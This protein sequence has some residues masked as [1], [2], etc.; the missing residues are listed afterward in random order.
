MKYSKKTFGFIAAI[1]MTIILLLPVV[2]QAKEID[3]KE[4]IDWGIQHNYDL[5]EIRYNIET[6]ERNLEIL[7]AGNAIQ[8]NLDVTPIWNFGG[9]NTETSLLN[10]TV[11]KTIADDLN[12]SADISWNENDFAD[13]SFGEIV[14]GA[15]AS[16]QLEKQFFPDS[17]TQSEQQ[18]F[19]TENNIKKKVEELAW[20]EAE[21]QIDFIERYLSL[22]RLTEE[23]SLAEKSFQL[24]TEELER[25]KQQ[26]RLGEGGYQQEAE[27]KIAL[28]ETENQFLNLKQNLVQQQKE[29]YLELNLSEDIQVQFN[30]E[31]IY[32]DN[33]RS[34]M[35]Q[36]TLENEK[37]ETLFKQTLEKHYQIKNAYIDRE[38]LLKEAKWTENEGKPQINL[39]GGYELSD[40]SWYAMLDLSWN[41]SDGGAQKLKE[42][43]T[44]ATILQKEKELDQL[45]KT[46][47]LEMNQIMDQDK[48]YQLNLQAKLAASEQEQYVKNILEKQYQ[49]K[50]ISSTQWQ[51]QL[52]AL[53]EKEL[54]VKE[55]QDLLLVNRLRLAHFLGI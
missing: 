25:V 11:E 49:E 55:A 9:G 36:L 1:I 35:R 43:E 3:L 32:L 28:M 47:Q 48:Y 53:A 22:V 5:E 30:G 18:I 31:P 37:Q 14:E 41:L 19:Q 17:Y 6:L 24:A 50:I 44:E 34:N 46:L 40:N 21:K 38:S 12:I 54:K 26:I 8:V 33:L 20:K 45:V 2:L 10:L 52:I 13:I 23:V 7:D 15:N 51:N 39:S 16:I 42:K 29:W 4:A 27:A